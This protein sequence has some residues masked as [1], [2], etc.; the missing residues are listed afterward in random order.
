MSLF[1]SVVVTIQ[2][3]FAD[4]CTEAEA[5]CWHMR[6]FKCFE[7]D[8]HL[9]GQRYIMRAARPYCCQCFESLYAEPCDTCGR[10]I[11]VDQGQMS[12]DGRHWHASDT[13]FRCWS[14]RH[15]LVGQP[16]LPRLGRLYCSV[17]CCRRSSSS[18]ATGT[19]SDEF[20]DRTLA[21]PAVS[22]LIGRTDSVEWATAAE[23]GDPEA[24]DDDDVINATSAGD[25]SE[26]LNW[27]RRKSPGVG[28]AGG[29]TMMSLATMLSEIGPP[30]STST[31]SSTVQSASV[32]GGH[33]SDDYTNVVWEFL[34][35]SGG[36]G[37]GGGRSG[38]G[39]TSSAG[40]GSDGRRALDRGDRRTPTGSDS[41][42]PIGVGGG[43]SVE[44]A[45]ASGRESSASNA[46]SR[47]H[48]PSPASPSAVSSPTSSQLIR[49]T[50]YMLRPRSD[51]IDASST[52]TASSVGG[53]N[54]IGMMPSPSASS[55][56]LQHQQQP[57]Y[58]NGHVIANGGLVDVR[59]RSSTTSMSPATSMA[60]VE[61]PYQM[62]P[63]VNRSSKQHLQGIDVDD[64]RLSNDSRKPRQ[65]IQQQR[66]VQVSRRPEKIEAV[67]STVVPR[68]SSLPD[69]TAPDD[70]YDNPLVDDGE[71]FC[72]NNASLTSPIAG[73][74][75]DDFGRLAVSNEARY[76]QQQQ[77]SSA[78]RSQRHHRSHRSRPNPEQPHL[79]SGGGVYYGRHG[80]GSD[81]GS[82]RIRQY[83][84]L[85]A[86]SKSAV[87]TPTA[88]PVA[89]ANSEPS[90]RRQRISGYHSDSVLRRRQRHQH[91]Q[92]SRADDAYAIPPRTVVSQQQQQLQ[93][94]RYRSPP[95]QP[96]P[97]VP[98]A[99]GV[100]NQLQQPPVSAAAR[101][102]RSV[103]QSL[104][105]SEDLTA[106]QVVQRY[107][108]ATGDV[109]NDEED[110]DDDDCRCST[111]SS[112]SSSSDSEFDYYLDRRLRPCNAS[113]S[114]YGRSKG[115]SA[116]VA[117]GAAGL[118]SP[119]SSSAALPGVGM[120]SL[121][122]GVRRTHRGSGRRKQRHGGKQC[123]IS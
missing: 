107:A 6:H 17:A 52:G 40:N 9:G 49:A 5:Q 53:I 34:E 8:R 82:H 76:Q 39:S 99:G 90:R 35:R 119:M 65:Q 12:H 32:I 62:L 123:V 86:Q 98:I 54:Q 103:Y 84:V 111:C 73:D 24:R 116:V 97:L 13:C 21:G 18:N 114:R 46:S 55:S 92:R 20:D 41:R 115:S 1:V 3:I 38:R 2:I 69:L 120:T 36:G 106:E 22:S 43:G 44:N 67:V 58:V 60:S 16:F 51:Q 112:S 79:G 15:S 77:P 66:P 94:D 61:R 14:C 59:N 93:L 48:V 72:D 113:S 105:E 87:S 31:L 80:S 88:A 122:P 57:L 50:D 109:W 100:H 7:C 33:A 91:R 117:S 108:E 81:V 45:R 101:R 37:G 11:G 78:S 75:S 68:Q 42:Y 29:S 71:V 56:S 102:Q 63:E 64:D 4:E 89:V 104:M 26:T 23:D 25:D 83:D 85:P 19:G 95:S 110:D 70:E 28:V 10:P 121:Q 96:Q 74:I 27:H 118:S 30:T 47:Q